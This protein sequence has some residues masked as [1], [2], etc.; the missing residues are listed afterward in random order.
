VGIFINEFISSYNSYLENKEPNLPDLEIQYADYAKW[1]NKWAGSPDYEQQLDY[2]KSEFSELPESLNL[3]FDYQRPKIK[4]YNGSTSTYKLIISDIIKFRDVANSSGCSTFMMFLAILK[5]LLHKYSNS[6]DIA[7][8]TP[9]ANRERIE[10]QGLIGFFVNTLVIRNQINSENTFIEFL[11][12]LKN[13]VLSSFDNQEIPFETIIEHIHPDRNMGITPLFQVMFSYQKDPKATIQISNLSI[14]QFK[15]EN[16]KSKF[17]MSFSISENNS[18]EFELSIEYDTELFKLE[19][20]D[21]L[22]E[23]FQRIVNVVSDDANISVNQ[24]SVLSSIDKE[25]YK[26]LNSANYKLPP[27]D[28]LVDLFEQNITHYGKL[29]AV[30][31]EGS[32]INYSDLNERSNKLARILLKKGVSNDSI[33][34]MLFERSIDAIV[35]IVAIWK[36]G[37]AYLPL[38]PTYP[39]DRIKQ[40][41]EDAKPR[42]LVTNSESVAPFNDFEMDTLKIDE[43]QKLLDQESGTNI[44][45]SINSS[46][47]A[48]V[49]YTSGSTGRPKG[50][51]IEHGTVLNLAYGLRDRIYSD[52]QDNLTVS[53]NAP[54]LFD[55][56][57]QQVIQLCFG[58]TLNIIPEDVRIDGEKSR[59][60]FRLT[61]KLS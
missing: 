19:T 27:V 3:P 31:Y 7:I 61:V 13:K 23:S 4:K 48:Y 10:I 8:G 33:V 30:I 54:L 20:I 39:E 47:L 28:S 57:V 56:S 15:V 21:R 59:G 44:G 38:V 12:T 37:G 1:Q 17:D 16:D 50:V 35:T 41:L 49:I 22:A 9:I 5:I 60:A 29:N 6:Q 18:S 55:A 34:A 36:A 11:K 46:N 58:H 45:V 24:I 51:M 25:K 53:L 2:W 14:E 40:I 43:S 32:R 52:I 42:F 26:Q